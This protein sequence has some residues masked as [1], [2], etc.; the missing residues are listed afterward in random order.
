[1]GSISNEAVAAAAELEKFGIDTS[2]A[3]VSSFNPDP[4]DD[5]AELLSTVPHVISLEAQ[6]IS[7]GLAAL[8][9][10]V[11]A[12]RGLA[13]RLWPLAVRTSPDGRSGSQIDCWRRHGLDRSAI[14]NCALSIF[15]GPAR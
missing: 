4:C 10:M 6:T 3:V 14:V 7:G 1:M 8:L 13:C 5:L 12:T 2:V 9:G 11:I 15:G